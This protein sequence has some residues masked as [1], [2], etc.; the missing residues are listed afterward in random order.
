MYQTV[1]LC[2][3]TLMWSLKN[4]FSLAHY[5]QTSSYIA[6][7]SC[8]STVLLQLTCVHG[9]HWY[10]V[11]HISVQTEVD[12][13]SHLAGACMDSEQISALRFPE[14]V[15]LLIA[16]CC[17]VARRL[18]IP[19]ANIPQQHSSGSN[20]SVWEQVDPEAGEQQQNTPL[21]SFACAY[22][23]TIGGCGEFCTRLEPDHRHHRCRQHRRKWVQI[24][25]MVGDTAS[26][27]MSVYLSG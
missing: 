22:G 27:V 9:F 26:N 12:D 20:E 10:H 16:L 17:E 21:P 13:G 4:C 1:A 25:P 7:H 11:W 2:I 14:L 23:C 8:C 3:D 5:P 19:I 15:T 18:N 24:V 6:M